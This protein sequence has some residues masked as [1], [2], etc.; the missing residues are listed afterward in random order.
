MGN[1]T[2]DTNEDASIVRLGTLCTTVH[3]AHL[4]SKNKIRKESVLVEYKTYPPTPEG[5]SS[6]DSQDLDERIDKRVNQL[7]GL[8][9][10][11]GSNALGTL[12]FRG[13]VKEADQ[14]RYAFGSAYQ[15]LQQ[16]PSRT[17]DIT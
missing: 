15:W 16:K 14:L 1:C 6:V 5:I 12:P 8:L 3:R 2:V 4:P 13:F 10:T 9:S 7:A 11:A 17:R